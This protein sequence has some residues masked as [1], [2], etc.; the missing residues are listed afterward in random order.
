MTH[1]IENS[2]ATLSNLLVQVQEQANRSQDFLAPTDQL[3]LMTGDRGMAVRSAR[4]FWSSLVA[5]PPK[6]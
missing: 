3:V 5:C 2:S 1:S 6:S 4:L